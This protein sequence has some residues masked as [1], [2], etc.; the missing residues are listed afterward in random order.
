MSTLTGTPGGGYI[1]TGIFGDPT[2]HTMLRRA[3]TSYR[4]APSAEGVVSNYYAATPDGPYAPGQTVLTHDGRADLHTSA[5][6]HK[7]SLTIGGPV[8]IRA[9]DIDLIPAGKR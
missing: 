5:R 9:L 3:Y 4:T 1:I 7:L 8:C 6:W 2:T